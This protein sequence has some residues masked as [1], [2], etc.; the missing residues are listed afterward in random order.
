MT[1]SNREFCDTLE[2]VGRHPYSPWWWLG[3]AVEEC[4]RKNEVV[5]PPWCFLHQEHRS[6][7]MLN[8]GTG[9]VIDTVRSFPLGWSSSKEEAVGYYLM[10]DR[11]MLDQRIW[12]P[13]HR[14][15]GQRLWG[16]KGGGGYRPFFRLSC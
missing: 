1:G 15:Q 7:S 11:S 10:V 16:D 6:W 5:T 9:T 4:E 14:E 3:F 13:G 8:E 12:H 2:Q